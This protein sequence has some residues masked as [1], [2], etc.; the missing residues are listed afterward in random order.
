MEI[1]IESRGFFQDDDY[2]WLKITEESK[3]RIDKQNLPAMI[4]EANK[5]IDSEYTSVVLSRKNN[6]LLCLL[7]GIKPKDRVDFVDRQIRISIAWV[8]IDSPDN[9]R[10]L[11]MLAV[12]ALNTEK[13]LHLT[14]E[15]S[16]AVSL[17]GELGFQ[18]DF[19]HIQ[20]LTN[21]EQA[22]KILQDKLPNTTK[23]IAETSLQRQQELAVE[24][25]EYRLP[26]Q[27][28]LIVVVTGIK[29]E[30]T[31]IDADIWRGLSSLVLS[32]DWQ[33]VHRTLPDKNLTNKLSKYFNN[34]MIIIGVISAVSLLVKTL[35]FL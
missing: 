7:T 35:N 13:R 34:L 25:K 29:K 5:L 23:K 21:T 9:E 4:Q 17:G 2:R 19:Q 12:A 30:Q 22:Q 24:L 32:S 6:N 8:V 27:Q 18:V 1:Y 20:K 14:T 26:T 16:Q 3:A 33:I 11:R 31:L 15:I 10:V 28:G